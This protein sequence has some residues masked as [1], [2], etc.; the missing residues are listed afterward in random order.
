MEP[1]NYVTPIKNLIANFELAKNT[2]FSEDFG[3]SEQK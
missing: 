3:I 1:C 2:D